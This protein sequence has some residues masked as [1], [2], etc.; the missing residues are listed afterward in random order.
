MTGGSRIYTDAI[1]DATPYYFLKWLLFSKSCG[2]ISVKFERV[3]FGTP[4]LSVELGVRAGALG[5]AAR[6]RILAAILPVRYEAIHCLERRATTRS[7]CLTD[8][9]VRQ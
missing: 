6:A 2:K 1:R 5:F 7:R 3:L 8:C 9:F 4:I